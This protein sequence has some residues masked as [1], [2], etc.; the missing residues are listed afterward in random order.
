[1]NPEFRKHLWLEMTLPRLIGI[2]VLM[3]VILY[4]GGVFSEFADVR[5]YN[6]LPLILFVIFTFVWGAGQ[7]GQSMTQ[8][9]SDG[10]WDG[11][12]LS[13]MHPWSLAWGRLFGSTSAA[14]YGGIIAL[15]AF[16]ILSLFHGPDSDNPSLGID[17]ILTILWLTGCALM[18]QILTLAGVLMEI[19]KQRSAKKRRIHPVVLLGMLSL[20]AVWSVLEELFLPIRSD[21]GRFIDTV[22]WYSTDYAAQ[23][24][25][26]CVLAALVLWGLVAL[27]HLMALELGERNGPWAWITFLLF[28]VTLLGGFLPGSKENGTPGEYQRGLAML[29]FGILVT[30]TYL[31]AIMEP[32]R[33]EMMR[34]LEMV[35]NYGRWRTLIDLTPRWFYTFLM[36]VVAGIA[37][38]LTPEELSQSVFNTI[39]EELESPGRVT[40]GWMILTILLF[41]SRDLLLIVSYNLS[42]TLKRPDTVAILT[43]FLL[44]WFFP[45]LLE[46]MDLP[47]LV[48]LFWPIDSG[49][50]Y[51]M[52]TMP[53]LE[54]LGL[55]LLVRVRWRNL[56]SE[57]RNEENRS[58]ETGS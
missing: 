22:T 13:A 39:L 57:N 5:F 12:R 29:A 44:Y 23:S 34:R 28:L 54:V 17:I 41:V 10:S 18:V 58:G 37:A 20:P 35:A 33:P 40:T 4:L 6:R 53:T 31:V 26:L 49:N 25:F 21:A 19:R 1:M 48:P 14:W 56:F 30:M 15:A 9:L 38:A 43:F 16:I 7:A 51:V 27:M 2:P 8:E 3:A 36:A 55:L 24:F 42:R 45:N 52:V 47:L 50:P 46:A 11:V 32:K